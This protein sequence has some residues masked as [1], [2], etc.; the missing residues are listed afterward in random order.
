MIKPGCLNSLNT[1]F[2]YDGL[3][4]MVRLGKSTEIV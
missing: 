2:C 1:L 3:N 4:K